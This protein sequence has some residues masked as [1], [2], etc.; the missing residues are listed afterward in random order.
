MAE[1]TP[2]AGC[3]SG[4]STAQDLARTETGDVVDERL[5]IPYVQTRSNGN[6]A[7]DLMI[8]GAHCAGCMAKIERE[9][10][11]LPDVQVARMNLSTMR[12]NVGWRGT[13]TTA[14]SIVSRLDA[15]GYGAKPFDMQLEPLSAKAELKSLLKAMAVAG[16]AMANIMVI[17]V[18]VWA[19]FDMGEHTRQILHILS[20]I[21]ALPAVAYAGQPFFRS[22]WGALKNKHTNMDVPIS[23]AVL[24]A[25]A[26]SIYETIHGNPDTYFDAA[27]MLLFLLLIGRY[28]DTRLRLRTGESAQRLAAMQASNASLIGDDGSITTVP[29]SL[30]KPGDLLLIAAGERVAVDGEI[31]KG[32]SAIDTS[33]ANG[34]TLPAPYGPG[35]TLYSGMINLGNPLHMKALAVAQDSFLSEISNLVE[36]GEQKKSKFVRI[37]DRAARAYVPIVHSL[38]FLT[39]VGWLMAGGSLRTASLNAIAVLIITCPCALGLAVPAVQIV[40]S[41]RLF[42]KGV[43]IKS[44]DAL[45]RLAKIDTIVFD[46]TGT[47]TLG[48]LK[49]TNAS[50]ID[51]DMLALAAQLA[52]G[53]RHPIARAIA[54]SAGDGPI[55]DNLEDIAG[56][57]LRAKLD[58]KIVRLGSAS[59]VGAKAHDNIRDDVQVESWLKVGRAKP[60]RFV[61]KDVPRMDARDTIKALSAH[62]YTMELLSGDT[63]DMTA[64]TARTLGLKNWTGNV[65]PRDKLAHLTA[66]KSAGRFPLM[67][68]DGIND[69]PALANATASAS[70][71]SAADISRAAADIILQGDKLSGLVTALL[72][73]KD[74]QKRVKENLSLAV[75]YNMIAVP[76]AISGHVNP[77]LAALAMSGSSILVTLNALRL[78]RH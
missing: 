43:L 31:I 25:C 50:E 58:G 3:P 9:I 36:A 37:A 4:Q 19:G 68:G 35:D 17:S 56:E 33:I 1:I 15:L 13:E 61:F 44:G 52:R 10:S 57:G 64:Q 42:K 11:A 60:I 28:L 78:A 54:D 27:V 16:A 47:L 66:L 39:F 45:E 40:A 76:L 65:S 46:K 24:L 34:E 12:L 74:A 69:A 55:A 59:F 71:A 23:L 30:I 49:L 53:S 29:A 67:V 14:N 63:A 48:Q 72:T 41:G 77:M 18:C 51:A 62:G 2:D 20:G 5:F 6:F 38:A 22:A 7:V 8:S 75:L 32:R 70:P 73:A 26:L 21:I